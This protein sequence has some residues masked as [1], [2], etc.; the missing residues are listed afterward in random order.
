MAKIDLPQGTLDLLVLRVLS[1]EQCTAGESP[2]GSAS[3]RKTCC[4]CRRA[5]LTPGLG[6]GWRPRRVGRIGVGGF[7][8]QPPREGRPAH[9]S[10]AK[11]T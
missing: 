10:R 5:R 6:P 8:E 1:T 4:S 7:G 9:Q 2:N 11:T 3:F